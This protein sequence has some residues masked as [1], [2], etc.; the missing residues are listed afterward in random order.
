MRRALPPLEF[1]KIFWKKNTVKDTTEQDQTCSS[2][3]NH[4]FDWDSRKSEVTWDL[5]Q[6]G[7][8]NKIFL[9][10]GLESEAEK[11]HLKLH[12][13]ETTRFAHYYS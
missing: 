5:M 11:E 4:N 13:D 12:E 6:N 2:Q 10:S 7:L 1:T 8:K 9:A 3:I